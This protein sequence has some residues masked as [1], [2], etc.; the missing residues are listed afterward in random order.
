MTNDMKMIGKFLEIFG[1]VLIEL[2][3]YKIAK[4]GYNVEITGKYLDTILII[5]KKDSKVDRM[6]LHIHNM[7]MEIFTMDRDENP[8]RFDYGVIDYDY[9]E[10]KYEDI[11][12]SR[13]SMI[14]T[15]M[16]SDSK[17]LK[18]NVI[19]KHS[20]DMERINIIEIDKDEKENKN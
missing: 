17:N 15:M 11:I 14:D 9:F 13:V 7:F 4:F 12:N 10:K 6:E 20:K 18:E 19:N 8:L 2:T 1:D 3:K 5:S 16:K